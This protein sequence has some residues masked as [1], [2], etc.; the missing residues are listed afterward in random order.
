MLNRAC[1]T[2]PTSKLPFERRCEPVPDPT[3]AHQSV[4]SKEQLNEDLD[5]RPYFK[6]LEKVER[7]KDLAPK[8]Q[9]ALR[10]KSNDQYNV[11]DLSASELTRLFRIT[12][13]LVA[14][15]LEICG[16]S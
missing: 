14:R 6:L 8:L 16:L 15:A 2:S 9:T 11:N 4:F 10:M 12:D 1:I 5:S 13:N 3:T 7:A